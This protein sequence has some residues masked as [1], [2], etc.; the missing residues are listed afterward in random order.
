MAIQFTNGFSIIPNNTNNNNTPTQLL[1]NSDFSSGT[2]GWTASGGFGTWSVYTSAERLGRNP[3]TG[4][5]ITI[6]SKNRI[7]FKKKAT[8]FL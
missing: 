5:S 4:E 7:K 8:K 6:A 2:T 3:K 1:T